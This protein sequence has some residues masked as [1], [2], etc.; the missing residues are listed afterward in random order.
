VSAEGE[1]VPLHRTI[2]VR[3]QVEEWLVLLEEAMK[4]TVLVK[5]CIA[6]FSFAVFVVAVVA[7]VAA[8][9]GAAV[10]LSRLWLGFVRLWFF[11]SC[12]TALCPL[13]RGAEARPCCA[14]GHRGQDPVQLDPCPQGP[15]TAR[16]ECS[17]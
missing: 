4:Q 1:D 10:G 7:T 12:G 15:G 13:L 16:G 8:I 3:G 2:K 14:D 9:G 6:N 17:S 11:V 5:C